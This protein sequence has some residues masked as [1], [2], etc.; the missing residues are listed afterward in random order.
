M[1]N[2]RI[3][4]FGACG[5]APLLI[6][7]PLDQLDDFTRNLLTNDEVLAL[8]QDPLGKMAKQI[9]LAD[10][11]SRV[12]AKDLEDGSKAVGFFNIGE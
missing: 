1:S 5:R 3:S 11:N 6:G 2:T 8:N 12:F 7:C 4:R 9:C 10:A